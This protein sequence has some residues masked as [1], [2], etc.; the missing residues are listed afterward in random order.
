MS[1]IDTLYKLL[2]RISEILTPDTDSFYRYALYTSDDDGGFLRTRYCWW[3]DRPVRDF[4]LKGDYGTV[5]VTAKEEITE[6]RLTSR[7]LWENVQLTSL[8]LQIHY[9][10]R[11]AELGDADWDR[12][13][14]FDYIYLININTGEVKMEYRDTLT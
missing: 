2:K 3:D 8:A 1:E 11:N 5:M 14:G 12:Q 13:F 6:E 10:L 7:K 4:N 9:D